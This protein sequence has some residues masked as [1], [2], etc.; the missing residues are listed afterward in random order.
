MLD[1]NI[2]KYIDKSVLCWLATSDND[3]FPNVSPKEMFTY[4]GES[5]L[6]IANLASPNTIDNILVNPNVCV[7][8]VDVFIQKGFK[9]K[10]IARVVDNA[11]IEF[12]ILVK[13]LINLFSDTFP[14]LSVI[15]INIIKIDEIK[16]PSYFLYKNITEQIQI[17]N[18]MKTYSVKPR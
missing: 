17:E 16:A 7:S 6:L 8:F 15:E 12:N 13:P 14:I 10:G 2:K 4:L 1:S 9:V 11:D 3:N 18:A 5:T